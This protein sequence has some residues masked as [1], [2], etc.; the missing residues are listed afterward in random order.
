MA[1]GRGDSG[2]TASVTVAAEARG[3]D[4]IERGRQKREIIG[5]IVRV[6][7]T[8]GAESNVALDLS[9]GSLHVL[10]R[11]RHLETR[12]TVPG[13]RHD[14]SVRELLDSLH[15]GS[16]WSDDK[17]DNPVRDSN[18]YGD[19]VVFGR[20]SERTGRRSNGAAA[21]RGANL[22]EVIGGCQ[23]LPLRCR[24]VF[25]SAGDD[26]DWLFATDRGLDVGVGLGPQCLDLAT[27][28][29]TRGRK[30]RKQ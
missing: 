17:P 22:R 27:Y 24:H 13:R 6:E 23:N 5:F 14:V 10:G 25:R 9:L 8:A 18:E 26:E 2:G 28:T 4:G 11:A 29:T 21:A 30:G 16:F 7:T 15:G 20:R 19:F 12:L 3:E 1:A